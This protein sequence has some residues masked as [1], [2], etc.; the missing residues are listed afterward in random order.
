MSTPPPS[1]TSPR[2]I[3]ES[4]VTLS[5]VIFPRDTNELRLATAGVILKTIDVAASLSA[6]KHCRQK[7]V[8]ASL[9]RMDFL[10]PAHLW[11]LVSTRCRLTQ[12][13]NTSMEI[14]VCVTAEA[15]KTGDSRQVALGYLVFV[16]LDDDMKPATVPP[17]ILENPEET[18][19]A[20]E[21]EIRKKNRL[22]E[23]K[24]IPQREQTRIT[25]ADA[26]AKVTRTMTPDDSNIHN[27]VFGGAILELVHQAGE[28]VATGHVHGP[29]IAVRQDRMNF[30]HSAF[31]GEEVTAR[32]VITRT[33]HTSLEVQVD[34]E[35]RDHKTQERRKIASSF[36][37]FV[38]QD[39]SGHP[40]PVPPFA[41]QTDIQSQRW[42]EAD[43]RRSIR[44]LERDLLRTT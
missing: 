29:V 17:L 14:E 32:A 42:Y 2:R 1:P 22:A 38:A 35:A 9:D 28:R 36:L 15:V 30:E 40:K 39:E 44:L 27:R 11:E 16:A 19:R 37:V 3:A 23:A 12:T 21:A 31:I 33:W 24:I 43:V 7:I 4:E 34:V 5:Q 41:P 20:Q 25:E 10:N 13:W 26:Y 18:R 6:G 8:T